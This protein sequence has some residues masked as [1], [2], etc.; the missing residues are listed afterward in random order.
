MSLQNDREDGTSHH[1]EEPSET[2]KFSASLEGDTM[3]G[4]R[5]FHLGF[6]P[7]LLSPW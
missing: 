6:Q 2:T 5:A 4:F 3:G 1:T 7:E